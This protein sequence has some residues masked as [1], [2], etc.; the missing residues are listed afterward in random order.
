MPYAEKQGKHQNLIITRLSICPRSISRHIT[1]K[2][3]FLTAN[4]CRISK[5]VNTLLIPN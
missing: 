2:L 4:Q 1:G 3:T 5:K